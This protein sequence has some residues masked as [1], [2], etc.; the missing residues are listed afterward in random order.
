MAFL[1]LKEDAGKATISRNAHMRSL[2]EDGRV[3]Y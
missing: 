2:E 3:S 1:W